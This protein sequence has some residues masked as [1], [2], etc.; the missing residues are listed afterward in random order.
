MEVLQNRPR[1]PW[2]IGRGI[3]TRKITARQ[4]VSNWKFL[5]SLEGSGKSGGSKLWKKF[6]SGKVADRST[7][8]YQLKTRIVFRLTK[9]AVQRSARKN[10]LKKNRKTTLQLLYISST[11]FSTITTPRE[12]TSR[13][14]NASL[15]WV[16]WCAELQL[17]DLWSVLAR[18][19]FTGV[20]GHERYTRW[21]NKNYRYQIHP[22]ELR[23]SK[24]QA[25]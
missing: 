11:F 14:S 12:S 10:K 20:I 23:L 18:S 16:L 4:W 15:F 19:T 22:V 5:K 25:S 7:A 24:I 1:L 21:K 17:F 9:F 8:G 3:N 13:K 2:I 6:R